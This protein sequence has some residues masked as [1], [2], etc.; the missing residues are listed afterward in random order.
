MMLLLKEKIHVRR[1]TKY[2]E[3][4]AKVS[5][6]KTSIQ[7]MTV[8]KVLTPRI[9]RNTFRACVFGINCVELYCSFSARVELL[10]DDLHSQLTRLNTLILLRSAHEI[11]I[12]PFLKLQLQLK[13]VPCAEL[14]R[15]RIH[16]HHFT[17]K[18]S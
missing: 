16:A 3:I 7:I 17:N 8:W 5:I 13:R 10:E 4:T 1:P 9:S 11:V 6:A 15:A 18:T 14:E 2:S 12:S